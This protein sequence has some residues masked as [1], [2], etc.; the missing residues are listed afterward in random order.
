MND[1][2]IASSVSHGISVSGQTYISNSY[3]HETDGTGWDMGNS[4][5][6]TRATPLSTR[7]FTQQRRDQPAAFEL[8]GPSWW[9]TV[10]SRIA[11]RMGSLQPGEDRRTCDLINNILYKNGGLELISRA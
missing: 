7:F 4:S 8:A 10:T 1:T 11:P 6:K 2:E 5:E 9:S 3:I